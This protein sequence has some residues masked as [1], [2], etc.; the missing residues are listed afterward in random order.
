MS[1][2]AFTYLRG[3]TSRPIRITLI[4]AAGRSVLRSGHVAR[5]VSDARCLPGRHC[6]FPRREIQELVVSAAAI[7]RSM[8]R[9]TRSE[10][11][12]SGHGLQPSGEVGWRRGVRRPDLQTPAPHLKMRPYVKPLTRPE[13]EA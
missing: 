9:S 13:A 4:S 1:V 11:Q 2:E 5:R 6:R 10:M 12:L 7:S 3:R 8:L